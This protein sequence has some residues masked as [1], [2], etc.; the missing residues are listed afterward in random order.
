M[1]SRAARD[2]VQHV[3]QQ[4][5]RLQQEMDEKV[6]A[7]PLDSYEAALLRGQSRAYQHA[8]H[9]VAMALHD[10]DVKAL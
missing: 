8:S 10:I 6:Q 1:I 9:L 4:L 2:R 5:Q 7:D 3:T